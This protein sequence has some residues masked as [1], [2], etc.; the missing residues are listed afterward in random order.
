MT[1]KDVEQINDIVNGTKYDTHGNS[2]EEYYRQKLLAE[3]LKRSGLDTASQA[4]ILA[5][6]SEREAIELQILLK[7]SDIT[8]SSPE[9]AQVVDLTGS[10]DRYEQAKR[11]AETVY[12][13]VRAKQILQFYTPTESVMENHFKSRTLPA[14]LAR[15][16]AIA[17]I[18]GNSSGSATQIFDALSR[19]VGL[20]PAAASAAA[21]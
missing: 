16:S 6:T 18:A 8:E 21:Q 19:A 11:L 9:F 17:S 7:L 4:K 20:T 14:A 5:A 10:K 12:D 13:R 3:K 15:T 2:S 1:S